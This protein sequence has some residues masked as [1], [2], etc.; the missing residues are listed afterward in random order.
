MSAVRWGFLGAGFIAGRALAPA[1]HA[2]DGAVLQMAAARDPARAAALGPVR[3][4]A[5]YG[6]VLAA[7]DVDAVYISLPNDAH[8]PWA[9]AALEAGKPVLCEKPL[10]LDAAQ[11]RWMRAAAAATGGLLVEAAWNRWHPRSRRVVELV[12]EVGGPRAVRT[13]F[14]FPSVPV[15][16]YRLDPRHGGGALLD[17]G[18]Y[19][20][21][22]ALDA[23]GPGEVEVAAVTRSVGP[24]GVDLT[25]T[26]TLTHRAGT[27]EVSASFERPG[28][29]GV[30][31]EAPGMVV[32]LL[33]QAFT[34]W[35]EPSALRV[36]RAGR[37]HVEHFAACDA[38]RLMVEA[39]GERVRGG[40]AWVMPLDES[41]RVAAT[42]DRI[43][44]TPA[45]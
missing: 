34:S 18:C 42:L 3:A 38:Y 21:G 2:A 40:S 22:A 37:E 8:L 26:A 23:L 4:V 44:A 43:A 1:V 25:T 16:N 7:D 5:D 29:Q 24:T 15:G 28:A 9:V 32:E 14:E 35:H 41:E 11:V 36:V 31:I 30:R 45:P 17:V 6:E 12:A 19:A 13:W 20:V 39:V 27:A 10:G 33:G